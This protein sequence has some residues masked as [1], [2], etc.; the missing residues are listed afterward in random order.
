MFRKLIYSEFF[1]L[2]IGN[3]VIS[4]FKEF[5]CFFLNGFRF[6]FLMKTFWFEVMLG[7]KKNKN[8]AQ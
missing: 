5:Y 1:Q 8:E 6:Q 3:L 2:M 4:I 7:I